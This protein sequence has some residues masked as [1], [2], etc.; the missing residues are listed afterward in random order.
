MAQPRWIQT[1]KVDSSAML[2]AYL[3]WRARMGDTFPSYN[4]E[5]LPLMQRYPGGAAPVSGTYAVACSLP[6]CPRCQQNL[7]GYVFRWYSPYWHA[8]YV[9]MRRAT[10]AWLPSEPEQGPPV[11]PGWSLQSWLKA[12]ENST[13]AASEPAAQ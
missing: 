6:G 7:G 9:R 8:D 4:I 3:A 5:D 10:D 2:S 1:Y 12:R 11:N 13:Y